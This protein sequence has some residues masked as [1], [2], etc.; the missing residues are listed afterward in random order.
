M[1]AGNKV[2]ICVITGTRA[3]Y[4][5]LYWLLKR[6]QS[7]KKF[8]L[9]II[10]TAMHLL[11]E[12]GETYKII[13]SDG[14]TINKKVKIPL[15]NDSPS[16]ISQAMGIAQ[17]GFTKALKTLKPDLILILGDRF[18]IFS[19]AITST[20]L[21]IPIA[22]CHGGETTQGAIDEPLRHSITKMSHLHFTST[23][24]YRNRVIQLG[25]NPRTV[26]NVG[27]LGIENI[28]R[29]KLLNKS[30]FEKAIGFK[31]GRKNILV[32]FHPVT[33]E[34]NTSKKQFIDLLKVVDELTDVHVIFTKPNA[35][36][37][38]Q[39]I[40]K[41]I[42]VYVSKNPERSI[43]FIS[44]GQLRYLSCLQFV[45][46]VAGNSSSGLIEVPS[47]KTA[48]INIGDR[49]KGRIKANSVIDCDANYMAIKK[50]F[51][52]A[53]S[54]SFRSKLKFTKNPYGNKNASNEIMRILKRS[55]FKNIL[56]KKFYDI[57]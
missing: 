52:K 51:I 20:V 24:K 1:S 23:Q 29:L 3:D 5:L 15:I 8:Q 45:D 30:D 56:K 48:T 13:E 50:A 33:L 38:G 6:I 28:N 57:N 35:D 40:T 21:N 31:L 17:I 36:T 18:E 54:K 14:F 46:V 7:E 10:A 55:D 42:D 27:A 34:N 19:A 4:G 39:I 2:K 22:H 26:F 53:Y 49:Q 44:M 16:H 37:N 47:F 41:L 9:Q 25:E 11:K 12:F 43:S 32:T